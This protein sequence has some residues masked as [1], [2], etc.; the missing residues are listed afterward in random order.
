[1]ID[2]VVGVGD[3]IIQNG[4]NSAVGQSVIQLARLRGVKTINVVRGQYVINNS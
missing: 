1:L 3:V 2:V 4:A